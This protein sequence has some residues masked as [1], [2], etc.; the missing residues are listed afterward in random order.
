VCVVIFCTP[1]VG[2]RLQRLKRDF[3][4]SAFLTGPQALSQPE[5]RS[6]FRRLSPSV[7]S[8]RAQQALDEPFPIKKQKATSKAAPARGESRLYSA[9]AVRPA[10]A[11]VERA[12][13]EEGDFDLKAFFKDKKAAVD[14]ALSLSVPEFA[15]HPRAS[16]LAEAM[17]YSLLAPAKRVRPILCLA[18]CELF[19][20]SEA[21]CMPTAVA[22]EMIH[23]MSLIHDDLPAMDNDTLR[24]GLP[25]NHVK[26]GEDIA[27]LAGDALL[28]RS[29]EYVA[30]YTH[31]VPPERI[32]QVLARLGESVGVEGLAGGQV[33][34]LEL[35]GQPDVTVDD[36]R[37]IH[38]HKTAALLKVAV[39]CG[40]ILGGAS[41]DDVQ[42]VEQYAENVGLAFQV[43]DDILD[44]TQS[45]EELGKTAGKD[46]DVSKTTYPKLLG[47]DGS[48]AEAKR[49]INEGIQ[50]L[51]PYGERAIPLIALAKYIVERKN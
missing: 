51:V 8:L 30:K 39:A 3:S 25:T 31:D 33:L 24:R 5:Q 23:S 20:G 35:E 29:F 34:D 10:P 7:A 40:A 11:V 41:S 48:K 42:R 43:H 28:S 18:A 17:R 15:S 37:W 4:A 9:T 14:H 46:A 38:R 50:L 47:L 27:I 45:T 21:S 44:V 22:I 26:Y 19:G 12:E 32:V 6:V 1:C 13:E 36:L 49:L 16:R 2:E